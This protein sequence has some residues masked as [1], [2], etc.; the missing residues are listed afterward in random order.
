MKTIR[1]FIYVL[2]LMVASTVSA[3]S[4][5]RAKQ[6]IEQGEYIEAAKIIRPLA[7]GGNAEAQFLAATLFLEGKGVNKNESQ[8][9]KYAK[10]SAENGYAEAQRFMGVAFLYGDHGVTKDESIG[11][12]YLDLAIQQDYIH[13]YVAKFWYFHKAKNYEQAFRAAKEG[14]AKHPELLK[15]DIGY[16]LSQYYICGLGTTKDVRRAYEIM[17]N[18]PEWEIFKINYK[19]E[20]KPYL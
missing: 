15:G 6:L 1:L 11:L 19:E 9:I 17:R 18:H 12:K 13:A 7:D 4:L 10:M 14:A 3:Q 5:Y 2:L 8:A 16:Y 20:L